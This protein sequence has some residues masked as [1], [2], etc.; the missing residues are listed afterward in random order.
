MKGVKTKIQIQIQKKAA[1]RNNQENPLGQTR[2]LFSN[3][4]S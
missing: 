2:Q 1:S 4:Q 3:Y